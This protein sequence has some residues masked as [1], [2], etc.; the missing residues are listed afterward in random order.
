MGSGSKYEGI[1]LLGIC[2]KATMDPTL[3]PSM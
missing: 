1:D 2:S 3:T